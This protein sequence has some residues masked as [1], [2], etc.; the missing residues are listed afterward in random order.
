VEGVGAEAVRV[1]ADPVEAPVVEVPK[2]STE[3]ELGI[4][5]VGI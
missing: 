3:L 1:I 2:V 5:P 4:L